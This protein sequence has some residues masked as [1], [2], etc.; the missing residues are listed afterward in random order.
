MTRFWQ[1]VG[2]IFRRDLSAEWRQ[3][4][5]L[6]TVVMFGLL[7]VVTFVFAFDPARHAR[8]EI[9]PGC[10]WTAYLFAGMLGLGRSAARDAQDG[11]TVGLLLSPADRGAVYLGKLFSH[12]SFMIAGELVVL[13][14][15]IVWFDLDERHLTVPFFSIIALGTIGFVAVGTVFAVISQKSRLREVMLP[16]LLLPVLAPMVMAAVEG[17]ALVLTP[18]AKESLGPWIN[19]LVGFDVVFAVAGFLLYGF[20]LE[21]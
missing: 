14:F 8:E 18:D 2:A 4:D 1:V 19:L 6:T 12:A 9:V 5:V 21:E 13:L 16:V 15:A 17:T 10:L 20:V 3:K 11:G 7:T